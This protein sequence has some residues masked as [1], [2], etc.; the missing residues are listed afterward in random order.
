M[1]TRRQFLRWGAVLAAAP[2]AGCGFRLRGSQPAAKAGLGTVWVGAV[3][4]EAFAEVL[5]SQLA[6]QGV[7]LVADATA[8]ADTRI[9]ILSSH[10]NRK[11]VAVDNSG[12]VDE[13]ELEL[14][15][16]YR[17]QRGDSPLSDVQ[18]LSAARS[19]RFD[20]AEVLGADA[21]AEV[22]TAEL[23]EVLAANLLRRLAQ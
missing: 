15:A 17:L 1:Q 11:A 14:V 12:K 3:P 2:L 4:G 8:E 18:S 7:T 10:T 13:Y 20:S 23:R 21:E 16:R 22:L 9:S 6:R 19:F 5:R